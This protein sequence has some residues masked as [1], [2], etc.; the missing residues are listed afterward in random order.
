MSGTETA[1]GSGVYSFTVTDKG[2]YTFKADGTWTFDPVV[3]QSNNITARRFWV[4]G[5]D[6]LASIAL[7]AFKTFGVTLYHEMEDTCCGDSSVIQRWT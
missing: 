2:T 7:N 6:K 3:D 4:Y 1:P 5:S